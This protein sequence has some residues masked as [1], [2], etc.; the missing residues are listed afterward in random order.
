MYAYIVLIDVTGGE[1]GDSE[2]VDRNATVVTGGVVAG[3]RRK[4]GAGTLALTKEN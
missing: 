2:L 3:T 4:S 1:L